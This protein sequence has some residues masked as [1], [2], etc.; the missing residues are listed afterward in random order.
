[1]EREQGTSVRKLTSG[2]AGAVPNEK[3]YIYCCTSL[4]ICLDILYCE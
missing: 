2:I 1:M 4:N 3:D